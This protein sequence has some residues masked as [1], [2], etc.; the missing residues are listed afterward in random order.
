MTAPLKTQNCT[1]LLV[2]NEAWAT[3][4]E[5]LQMDS[6]SSAFD[7]NLR[8][9]ISQALSQVQPITHQVNALLNV[10]E[11]LPRCNTVRVG[12]ISAHVLGAQRMSRLKKALRFFRSTFHLK[13][14]MNER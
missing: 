6:R 3:L 11:E 8:Q 2:P 5:T 1:V 9:E 7:T 12:R 14:K 10:A 13:G 4:H